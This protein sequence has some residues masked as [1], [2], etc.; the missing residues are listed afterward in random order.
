MKLVTAIIKPFRLD[1]VR[2]ALTAAGVSGISIMDAQG[3][4]RQ[5]NHPRPYRGSE[6]QVDFV[7]KVRLEFAVPSDRVDAVVDVIVKAANTGRVGDGKILISNVERVIG[8]HAAE[9]ETAAVT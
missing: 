8:I 2:E 1:K 9:S 7:P 6:Y 4:G 3:W 5:R